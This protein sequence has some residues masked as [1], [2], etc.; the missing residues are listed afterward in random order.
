MHFQSSSKYNVL[1]YLESNDFKTVKIKESVWRVVAATGGRLCK[2][3]IFNFLTVI[4]LFNVLLVNFIVILRL[5][6]FI[7]S[8]VGWYT[9]RKWQVLFRIY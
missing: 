8:R 3:K 9:R 1:Y 7:F 5:N 4:I 6:T 2:Y